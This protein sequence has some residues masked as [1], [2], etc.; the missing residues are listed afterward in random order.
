[1][2]PMLA[3]PAGS[4]IRWL[5]T[6]IRL[7]TDALPRSHARRPGQTPGT[8]YGMSSRIRCPTLFHE[9]SIRRR[10]VS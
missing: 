3:P 5:G 10:S 4:A 1:M 9:P 2:S 7:T 6:V 8:T